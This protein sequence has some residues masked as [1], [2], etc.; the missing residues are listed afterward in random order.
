VHKGK[1]RRE[2]LVARDYKREYQ[3]Y[4]GTPEQI[5]KRSL[6]NKARRLYEKEHGNLP[7][8]VDVDHKTPIAKGGGNSKANLRAR[9]RSANRSFKRTRNAGMA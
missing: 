9:A 2:A 8:S 4:Q 1:P 7:S 6:R 5:K 3:R